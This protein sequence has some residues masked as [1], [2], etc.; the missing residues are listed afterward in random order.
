MAGS[1]WP[2][3]VAGAKAKASEVE[4]KFDWVEGDIVPMIGGTKTDATYDLG[5]SSFRWRD[6]RWSRQT[7][8]PAGSVGTPS[9]SF[10]GDPNTGVY[11]HSA[12]TIGFSGNGSLIATFTPATIDIPS[13][14]GKYQLT[15]TTNARAAYM[16][17]L[18]GNGGVRFKS[19][20][21]GGAE[22]TVASFEFSNDVTTAD[23]VH[24]RILA[25]GQV[26]FD[27]GTVS[28]P[29]VSFLNDPNTGMYRPG[30]DTLSLAVAGLQAFIIQQAG[31]V[32]MP[33]QPAFLAY[34]STDDT[35]VLGG[36][37][38]SVTVEFDTEVFDQ[39]SDY[40]NA[41]D[42]FTAPVTGRYLLILNVRFN[43][44][45]DS[46]VTRLYI[47]FVTSNRTYDALE[48]PNGT[49]STDQSFINFSVV[50][51][52]DTNDTASVI[53]VSAGGTKIIDITNG[54]ATSFS[55]CLLA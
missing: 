30:S 50:A 1:S 41:T 10:V 17:I 16:G 28:I 14:S 19:G 32:T 35:D 4:A 36:A 51:D 54:P 29:A 20:P 46:T 12:D 13:D 37:T 38:T 33:L 47:Q 45:V 52:M 53:A 11:S 21:A 49:A 23:T 5:E 22:T 34:N 42:T 55:G 48:V 7:L 39:G 25:G 9:Y 26:Q 8:A 40:N 18:N 3:L 6:I 43:D 15:R 2:A 27:D 31:E 44:V 24:L